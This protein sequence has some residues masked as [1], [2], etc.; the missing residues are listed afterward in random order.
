MCVKIKQLR[1]QGWTLGRIA[2]E[3]GLRRETVSI[4]LKAQGPADASTG[5]QRGVGDSQRPV[6]NLVR[7]DV[8]ARPDGNDLRA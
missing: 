3:T 6:P 7:R 1:E 4:H 8:D 5:A 2:A